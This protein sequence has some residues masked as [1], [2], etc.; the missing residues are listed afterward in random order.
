MVASILN[1]FIRD[2]V[3]GCHKADTKQS[4]AIKIVNGELCALPATNF[5]FKEYPAKLAKRQTA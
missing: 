1:R 5:I 2:N 3:T 4:F